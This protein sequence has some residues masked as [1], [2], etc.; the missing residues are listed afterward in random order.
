[1][2]RL[3]LKI[4]DKAPD[5]NGLADDGKMITLSDFL[6]KEDVVLFFYPKDESLG[7]T[8]EAC[9][10]RDNWNEFLDLNATVIGVSSDTVESHKAFKSHRNLPFTLVSDEDSSIRTLYGAKGSLVAPRITFVIDRTGIIRYVF[11]SQINATKHAREALAA[12]GRLRKGT[13]D[14]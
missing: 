9:S 14:E 3:A 2:S 5:F 12:L 8:A 13:K 7:C 11:S 1:M 4:G 10:F 6:G